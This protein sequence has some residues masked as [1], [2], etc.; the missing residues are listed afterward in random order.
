ME[1]FRRKPLETGSISTDVLL[2]VLKHLHEEGLRNIRPTGGEPLLRKDWDTVVDEAAKIGYENIDITTNGILLENYLEGHGSLPKGLSMVKF[3]L[4]T[5]DP[6][7]F[8]RVTGGG[9]LQRVVAGI[10]AVAGTIYTRANRVLLKSETNEA[11][12]AEFINFCQEIGLNGVQ[13]LDLVHYNNLPYA[14]PGFFEQEFVSF[15]EFKPVIEKMFGTTFRLIEEINTGVDFYQATLPNGFK[16]TFKD[17]TKTRRDKSCQTCPVYCQEGRCLVRIATDGNLTL[18]PD[19]QGELPSFN[20]VDAINNG[21]LHDE[22]SNI[23]S[24]FMS[25]K[26]LPTFKEFAQRHGLKMRE[27]D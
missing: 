11:E 19:Y 9:D 21:T 1:D 18:C 24:I 4:D 6:E 15:D 13:Y 20:V 23:A 8:K 10:K 22:M 3:S 25:S 27:T 12:L 2:D 7:K 26:Q 5:H 17:S 16:I 14:D